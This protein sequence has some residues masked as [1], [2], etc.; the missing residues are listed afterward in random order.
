M[1]LAEL[2]GRIGRAYDDSSPLPRR[3]FFKIGLALSLAWKAATIPVSA[4]LLTPP[5]D[6][7][8]RPD[9]TSSLSVFPGWIEDSVTS[10]FFT[11]DKGHFTWLRLAVRNNQPITNLVKDFFQVLRQKEQEGYRFGLGEAFSYLVDKAHQQLG[12][13]DSV[14]AVHAAS[15]ALAFCFN[16]KMSLFDLQSVGVSLKEY[17]D[18]MDFFWNP[19]S[20]LGRKTF[21]K[22]FGLTGRALEFAQAKLGNDPKLTGQDR[23]MHFAN[24]FLL[25]FEYLYSRHFGLQ[26]HNSIPYFLKMRLLFS[27]SA[28]EAARIFSNTAGELYEWSGLTDMKNWPIPF[29]GQDRR[30][31]GEGVSDYMVGADLKGNQLGMEAA[32]VVWQRLINGQPLEP[33]FKE[34]DD[35]RFSRLETEPKFTIG[36]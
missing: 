14:E 16:D 10:P 6:N 23:T 3:N 27:S 5:K 30:K 15:V 24:H 1:S 7:N 18:V 28:E 19:A 36:W 35:P 12:I 25:V 2:G 8:R 17:K 32:I 4:S 26:E 20:G 31:I 11:T 9:H 34:L 21:P 13:D 33:V 22:L 29:I